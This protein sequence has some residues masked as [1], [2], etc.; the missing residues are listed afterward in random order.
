MTGRLCAR[1][2][3]TARVITVRPETS[4][5]DIAALM[6]THH[7]SGLPV[8]TIE[9]ELVGIVTEADLLYKETGQEHP[10]GRFF[11][12]FPPF[13][14]TVDTS[15]KAEGLTAVDLMSSPVI[16]V[17]EDTPLREVAGLMVRRKINR[18]P[19]MRG[20]RLAGIV[21]RADVLRAFTRPDAELA[22]TVREALLRE[23]WVDVS[24]IRVDVR[25]G[26]VHLDGAVDRR[27]ERDLVTRWVAGLD[28][29]VGVESR[30]TFEYDDRAVAL[31]AQWPTDQV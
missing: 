15:R 4:V 3:M 11:K 20:G 2:V 18:V 8:V 16:T 19:V 22:R 5:K 6:L 29:V 1:D 9:G 24:K 30:L 7:V 17:E 13:G 28:G 27:S 12:G 14:R 26:V 21:S 23:L 31:G 10:A 25:E